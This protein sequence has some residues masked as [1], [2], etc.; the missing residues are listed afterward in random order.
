MSTAIVLQGEAGVGKTALLDY[1]A[2][3]A[4]PTLDVRRLNGLEAETHLGFAALHRLLMPYFGHIDG[5]PPAQ[6]EALR[7]AFGL[8]DAQ[9]VSSFLL[10]LAVLNLLANATRDQPVVWIIDDVQ[11]LDAESIEILAFTARR[12]YAEQIGFF[13]A[14]REP[15]PFPVLE[16]IPAIQVA[17]LPVPEA[18]D[19][20]LSLA[21]GAVDRQVAT[22]VAAN[23]HGNPLLITEVGR[24]LNAGRTPVGLL[25]D[26]PLPL[27]ERLVSHFRQQIAALPA[28][29]RALLTYAAALPDHDSGLLR[30]AAERD[31][32]DLEALSAAVEA[33]LVEVHPVFKFRHSLIRSAVYTGATGAS[34][35]HAHRVLAELTDIDSDV[36]R[37]AWHL[38]AASPGPDEA[39]AVAL[40][41]GAHA[42]R[43]RGGFLAEAAHLARAA[44]LSPNPE[45]IAKRYLRAARAALIGGAPLRAQALLAAGLPYIHDPFLQ[46][47]AQKLQANALH[48]AG[49]PGHDTPATLLAAAR[50]FAP[51]EP[52]LAC[53]TMLEALEQT[54]VRG[55]AI[56][57][58]TPVEVGQ[59]A[60]SMAPDGL[61]VVAILLE[62]AGTFLCHGYVAAAPLM[63]QA[64]AALASEDALKDEVPRWFSLGLFL[65]Q[66]MWDEKAALGWLGRCEQLARTTGALDLLTMTLMPLSGIE[67]T[68]GQLAK[69]EA[70]VTD[71]RLVSRAAG[72]PEEQVARIT[73]SRLLAW[74]GQDNEATL[75]ATARYDEFKK[76]GAGN[77]ERLSQLALLIAEMGRF[78]YLEAFEV[79]RRMFDEDLLGLYQDVLPYLVE[80]GVR[81]GHAAEAELSLIMLRERAQASGTDWALGLLARSEALLAADENA[82][83]CFQLAIAKLKLTAA[84]TDL[85]RA[86]LLYGEWLRRQK[87]RSAAR[88]Q[89]RMAHNLFNDIG[90]AAF[91]A[92]AE[93]ELKAIGSSETAT[94]DL[95]TPQEAQVARLAAAGRTNQEIATQLFISTHTVEYH[96]RKVFRKL[97]V[98]SRRKLARELR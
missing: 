96:L 97:G 95:L 30:D 61:G 1:V 18:A 32:L 92:R 50:A 94:G 57:G 53:E 43:A 63:R 52:D 74:Q 77:N 42:A 48:R 4:S 68:L 40:E 21:P 12:V 39:V 98:S 60:L 84:R 85:A 17:G 75:A 58:T 54:F 8:T 44:E 25:L 55:H 71:A 22:R 35:R 45:D 65:A 46:A 62:S 59:A 88:D 34:R 76:I 70:L 81:S 36:D 89:L 9:P 56:E 28:D 78:R 87:R 24:E 69:A 15:S 73:N 27:S 13:F 90:A 26:D 16:G 14:V 38:A 66:L 31:G 11:W 93:S 83:A 19:L 5:L 51:T 91:A 10:G 29:C 79:A 72:V 47:Q 33:G 7:T 80:S 82:D 86:R 49:Q 23:S 67:A 20:L 37:R 41:H 6:S 64:L 3:S 2:E